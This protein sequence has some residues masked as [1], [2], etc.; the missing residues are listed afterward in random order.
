MRAAGGP[1]PRPRSQAPLAAALLAAPDAGDA[2]PTE[3]AAGQAFAVMAS[4]AA[5]R[6]ARDLGA[7]LAA[8]LADAG[9]AG[10]GTTASVAAPPCPALLRPAERG[11]LEP[12]TPAP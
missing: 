9:E 6:A 2:A 11:A 7:G 1:I 3:V 8:A 10:A 12:R 4:P 5:E